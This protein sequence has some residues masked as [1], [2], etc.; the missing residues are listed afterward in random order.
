MKSGLNQC[1]TLR[2]N[3]DQTGRQLIQDAVMSMFDEGCVALVPIDTDVDPLIS[4]G[5][6]ILSIRTGK[7][8]QWYPDAVRML[9]YN[10]RKGI[11]E[12]LTMPK[13][14]VAIVEN[15]FY[16]VM[17]E[18]SSTLQRL[19]RKLALKDMLDE[20]TGASKLDLIF[21]LPYTI[22][23]D[24]RMAEA[25][26][27]KKKLEDQLVNSQYGIAYI[28][29][30]EK[31]TQL[32]RP[33][34][35]NLLE[36]EDIEKALSSYL[37]EEVRISDVECTLV[38]SIPCDTGEPDGAYLEFNINGCEVC[39]FDLFWDDAKRG[40]YINDKQLVLDRPWVTEDEIFDFDV[41]E[42]ASFES[43]IDGSD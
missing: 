34:E 5:Y 10:E 9:V 29:A 2:P 11:K 16:A 3:I 27:R 7:I 14:S 13:T 21:Q 39:S 35:N 6:D 42:F 8:V 30:T 32:N 24:M 33:I 20:K 25:D 38:H 1:L 17:N 28:D 37:D 36:I 4:G 18:P 12:E 23:T 19:L 26:K 22:K 40:H 43:T 41:D 15:P 31:V